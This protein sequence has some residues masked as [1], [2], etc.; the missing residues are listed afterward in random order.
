[1]RSYECSNLLQSGRTISPD[2]VDLLKSCIL[3][4]KKTF[5]WWI[6]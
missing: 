1:M 4:I 5:E 2:D 6:K 3:N